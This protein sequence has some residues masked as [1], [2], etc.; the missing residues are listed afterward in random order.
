MFTLTQKPPCTNVSFSLKAEGAETS[1]VNA[2]VEDTA[3]MEQL[4]VKLSDLFGGQY[5]LGYVPTHSSEYMVT[6]TCLVKIK[7][8]EKV[9]FEGSPVLLNYE[10]LPVDAFNC[11]VEGEGITKAVECQWNSIVVDTENAGGGELKVT[12]NGIPLQDTPFSTRIGQPPKPENVKVSGPG[13]QDGYIEQEAKFN[14]ET[15][16]AGSGKLSVNV[17]GPK[18][19]FKINLDRHPDEERTILARYDPQHAGT[20]VVDIKWERVP[21]PGSPFTVSIQ[22]FQ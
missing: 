2:I 17:E 22:D 13:L 11:N 8:D 16:N 6:I 10:R 1:N 12:W 15:Q 9:I 18:G 19:G 20:Y 5:G 3:T 14:I 7:K 21:V 4:P